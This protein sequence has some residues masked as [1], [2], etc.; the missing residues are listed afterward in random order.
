MAVD[1]VQRFVLQSMEA[2]TDGTELVPKA[3]AVVNFKATVQSYYPPVE[4]LQQ[5]GGL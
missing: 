5:S 3:A 2:Y 4:P 1:E